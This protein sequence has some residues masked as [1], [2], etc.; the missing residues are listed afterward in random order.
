MATWTD[1]QQG[2]DLVGLPRLLRIGMAWYGMVRCGMVQC[3]KVLYNQVL[4]DMA[5]PACLVCF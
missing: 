1:A 4:Y 3:G 5:W 2:V